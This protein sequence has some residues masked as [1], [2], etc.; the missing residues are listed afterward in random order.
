MNE[1]KTE[2]VSAKDYAILQTIK[3]ID[4][5]DKQR[6]R[7]RA[8]KQDELHI[9]IKER[10]IKYKQEQL[11]NKTPLEKNEEFLDGKKPLFMLESDIDQIEFQIEDMRS[12]IKTTKEA[13]EED[14]NK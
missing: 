2:K 11:A 9:K 12:R 13:Y 5:E 10:E 6:A 3:A 1:R 14:K 7:L 4:Q 8:I